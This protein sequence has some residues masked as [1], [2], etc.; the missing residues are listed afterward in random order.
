MS[1]RKRGSEISVGFQQMPAARKW[2]AE[3]IAEIKRL[4]CEEGLALVK[5]GEKFN[6]SKPAIRRLL[7]KQGV[8]IRSNGETLLQVS[9]EEVN[10][11][12]K[13]FKSG[14]SISSITNSLGYKSRD[15]VVKHLVKANLY[16]I[17][18]GSRRQKVSKSD[19]KD[20]VKRYL[21]GEMMGS[22]AESYGCSNDPI[23]AVLK[24]NGVRLRTNIEYRANKMPDQETQKDICCFYEKGNTLEETSEKFDCA[25]GTVKKVLRLYDIRIRDQHESSTGIHPDEW[26]AICR[27]YVEDEESTV[28][29]ARDYKVNSATI[30]RIV[31]R[32]G[33]EIRNIQ[34]RHMSIP[35]SQ[36]AKVCERYRRGENTYSIAADL[37]IAA[38]QVVSRLLKMHGIEIRGDSEGGTDDIIHVLTQEGRFKLE[39]ETDFYIYSI[40]GH[41]NFKPGIAFSHE[42]RARDSR[43]VY[44]DPELVQT[45]ET[46]Q[47][48]W[49]VEYMVL[50]ETSQ[51]MDIPQE[52]NGWPGSYELRLMDLEELKSVFDFYDDQLDELGIYEYALKYVDMTEDEK[53]ICEER[54]G[55][56]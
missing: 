3:E 22:I 41:P 33:F 11:I 52:L 56:R 46:R 50:A 42:D 51:Y 55:R 30:A 39:R 9:K 27:R 17:K 23:R 44:K 45:Y 47:E 31:T 10:E 5:V 1:I 37:G 28:T 2:T 53:F 32:R 38:P 14:E 29:I 24:S 7:I 6:A 34:E 36:W 25:R 15:S 26:D 16:T 35:K 48:A 13:R 40:H 18:T 20:I 4:Y 19:H 12:L 43:G 8:Q 49:L 54:L 21:D